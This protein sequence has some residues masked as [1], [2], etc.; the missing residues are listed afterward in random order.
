MTEKKSFIESLQEKIWPIAQKIQ[1]IDWLQS[2]SEGLSSITTV[3]T[4]GSIALALCNL[5]FEGFQAVFKST[6]LYSVFYFIY[7][8]TM[9]ILSLYVVIGIAYRFADKKDVNPISAIVVSLMVYL[10]LLPIDIENTQT[11]AVKYLGAS[12]MFV[13]IIAALGGTSLI[14]LFNDK[15]LTIKL[16]DSVPSFVV[17]SFKVFISGFVV[18]V[19]AGLINWLFAKTSFGSLPACVYGL[20]QVPLVALSQT[21]PGT[22]IVTAFS[23]LVFFT[24]I[25]GMSVSSF[26]MPGKIA[27]SAKNAELLA[28]NLA[29]TEIFS[30]A[31][32]NWTSIGGA[33]STLGLCLLLA[34]VAKSKRYKTLGRVALVPQICNINEPILYGLPICLNP[35]M[36]I[37]FCTA[38]A[39][40]TIIYY[41]SIKLGFMAVPWGI[42]AGMGVP[43]V[44]AIAL[45]GVGIKGQIVFLVCL[46][47]DILLYYPFFKILDK[48][49]YL[50][51]QGEAE[52]Q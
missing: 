34:F 13:A 28:Q 2:I 26:L 52:K 4:T 27:A 10:V 6:G 32:M 50:Q 25:H 33:G 45:N 51:E 38:S 17:E 20:L 16:P 21:V 11:I 41:F 19:A 42:S 31:S 37:P 24:G 3:I 9:N 22:I 15:G 29:P 14:K 18:T 44:F 5:P 43:N 1:Q 8:M 35:V 36:I 46:A 40:T 48:Q 47:V 39:L 7:L 30:R 23:E 12:G 49:A